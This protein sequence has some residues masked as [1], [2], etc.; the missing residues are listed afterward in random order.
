[1]S[2]INYVA[3]TSVGENDYSFAEN[4]VGDEEIV[5]AAALAALGV[6]GRYWN[7]HPWAWRDDTY[8]E[9]KW[10]EAEVDEVIRCLTRWK[11]EY[12]ACRGTLL[13]EET[14]KRAIATGEYGADFAKAASVLARGTNGRPNTL[15][16]ECVREES[17]VPADE[18][19][20]VV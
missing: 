2:N 10:V 18:H 3:L 19:Q 6:M 16:R 15:F 8:D 4:V 9:A 14:V 7:D 1:M 12:L 20:R 5:G 13:A 11:K 17:D